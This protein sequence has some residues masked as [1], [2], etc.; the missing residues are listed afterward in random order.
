MGLKLRIS[1]KTDT[2][3]LVHPRKFRFLSKGPLGRVT[4]LL[5]FQGLRE[6][7]LLELQYFGLQN[8]N[9]EERK[10]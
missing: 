8:I 6:Q 7:L 5:S 2:A 1:F 9:N 4:S 3:E 10:F